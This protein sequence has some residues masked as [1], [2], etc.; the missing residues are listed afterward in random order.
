MPAMNAHTQAINGLTPATI[1]EEAVAA[2]KVND[3][4]AVI[5]GNENI[6]K[7]MK[8]PSA[9]SARINPMVVDPISNDIVIYYYYETIILQYV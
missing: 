8:I 2:P 5:S 9:S 1:S 6:L 4:S 3:P 7:L